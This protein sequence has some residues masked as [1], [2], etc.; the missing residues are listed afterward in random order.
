MRDTQGQHLRACACLG[1]SLHASQ[2]EYHLNSVPSHPI[3]SSPSPLSSPPSTQAGFAL[4]ADLPELLQFTQFP[5]ELS[6]PRPSPAAATCPPATHRDAERTRPT[7]T[8]QPACELLYALMSTLQPIR[9]TRPLRPRLCVERR[10]RPPQQPQ[11]F[12]GLNFQASVN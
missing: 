11:R 7:V 6:G 5:R 8:S 3:P 10:L 12:R 9:T 1:P 4:P 2:C